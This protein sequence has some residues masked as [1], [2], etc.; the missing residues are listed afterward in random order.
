MLDVRRHVHQ[1]TS[2]SLLVERWGLLEHPLLYLSVAFRRRQQEYYTRLA[3]VRTDGDWEGWT[4]FFLEC[5]READDDGV[6]VAQA[7][8]A[9][10]ARDRARL[11][12]HRRATIAAIQLLDQLPKHP[13]MTGPRAAE[14]LGLTVPPA[15]KAIEL[16]ARLDVLRETTGKQRDRVYAY[17]D[18]LRILTGDEG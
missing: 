1:T 11:V 14:V 12:D 7:L 3:A 15:R 10:L 16:L 9:L 18:Y 4:A 8:H 13:V 17:H 6:H 5:V 2:I